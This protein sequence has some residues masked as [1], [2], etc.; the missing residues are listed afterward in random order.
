MGQTLVTGGLLSPRR[1]IA[2]RLALSEKETRKIGRLIMTHPATEP[3]LLARALRG[4]LKDREEVELQRVLEEVWAEQ[5]LC[6]KEMDDATRVLK[7][8]KTQGFMLGL[9]SN[10]WHPLYSGFCMNCPE[11]A[12]LFD[13]LVLSF[14]LGYKKPSVN[15]FFQ[16]LEQA[17]VAPERCCMVGDSYE[18][19]MEP[20]L[21][22]G[23]VAIWVLHNPEKEKMCLA[24]VMRG[25]R[26]R[27]DWSVAHLAEILDFFP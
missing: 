27:P 15:M 2:S 16:A 3:S 20:A 5:C 7:T 14:R 4:I 1:L 9:L 10:T 25:E 18:L 21:A 17:G 24:Q 6:V 19:D 26:T 12:E 23:M 22:L 8:L 11:M 13:Y